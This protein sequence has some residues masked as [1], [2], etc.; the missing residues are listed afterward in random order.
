[1]IPPDANWKAGL[2]KV[3]R[4]LRQIS[5]G[6]QGG[7]GGLPLAMDYKQG[8]KVSPNVVIFRREIILDT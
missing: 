4:V 2:T 8:L 7:R 5:H 1:M 6:V 3:V